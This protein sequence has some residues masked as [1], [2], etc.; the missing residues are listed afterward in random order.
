MEHVMKERIE[1]KDEHGTGKKPYTSPKLTI[2]G[3]VEEIT[4]V[5]RLAVKQLP[6]VSD[7]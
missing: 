2:H 7:I 5:L 3:D 6:F 4:K 1:N